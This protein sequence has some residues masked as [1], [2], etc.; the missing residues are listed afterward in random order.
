MTE[1]VGQDLGKYQIQSE[2]AKGGMATVYLANQTSLGRQVAVKIMPRLITDDSFLARF[3]REVDVITRLQ[4]PHILPVYDYGEFDGTPYI[5]MAYINGGTLN[6]VVNDAPASDEEVLHYVKQIAQA[7]DYAHSKDIVHR[8]FKPANV[9]LDEQKNVYLADFGL[10][11]INEQS[12]QITGNTIVGTP[13]HMAPEQSGP[14]E[15]SPATDVYALGVTIFQLLTGHAPYEDDSP[16]KTLMAHLT[17][18]VPSIHDYREDLPLDMQMVIASAMAK[19]GNDRYQ[20]VMEL[21]EA[22]EDA[23]VHKDKKA[24]ASSEK[25]EIQDALLMTNMLGQVIFVD[26]QCLKILKRHHNEVR[27]IIGKPLHEVLNIAPQLTKQFVEQLSNEGTIDEAE[28]EITDANGKQVVIILSGA[29]TKDDKGDFVGADVSIRIAVDA[30]NIISSGNFQTMGHLLD[31]RDEA[32]LHA[33][34]SNH[35]DGFYDLMVNWAGNRA[36]RNLEN[37]INETASRNLW[38]INMNDGHV[39]LELQSADIDVYKALI[40]KATDYAIK[41][42]GKKAVKK[43]LDK[44]NKAMD[45]HM[46]RLVHEL[47]LYDI[48][49]GLL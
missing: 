24:T 10:A 38:A 30:N 19:D 25:V 18:P 31:N 9:L 41:V 17:Q 6:D 12:S 11:K 45:E 28:L 39:T 40:V 16:T 47:G 2:I 13:S 26:G 15:I 29:A 46:L 37:I 23:L 14:G 35:I 1:L 5:V 33:F 49:D 21:Y 44:T 3:H 4:H 8:D 42:I 48:F 22:L 43:R 36:G 27:H 32:V 34:F 20:S 7:L